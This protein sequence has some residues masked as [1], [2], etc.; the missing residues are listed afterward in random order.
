[1]IIAKALYYQGHSNHFSTVSKSTYT[2]PGQTSQRQFAM[3]KYA[4]FTT[5]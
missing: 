5:N 3:A 4:F 2:A 1:M